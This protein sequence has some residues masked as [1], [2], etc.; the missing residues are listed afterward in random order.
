MYLKMELSHIR[1][2]FYNFTYVVEE[3]YYY[4]ILNVIRWIICRNVILNSQ[5]V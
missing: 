1:G 3:I 4:P 5:P 2:A